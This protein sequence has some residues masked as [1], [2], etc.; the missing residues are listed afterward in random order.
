MKTFKGFLAVL[1]TAAM[2]V[3]VLA[4]SFSAS[5][6]GREFILGD[7]DGDS[8][9]TV[10]DATLV[11]KALAKMDEVREENMCAADGDHD[12]V[13]SVIDA[14][15]V[16]MWL[17]NFKV[18]YPIG[19]TVTE[20]L[21]DFLYPSEDPTQ[22]TQES[23]EP[24]T[25]EVTSE[26]TQEP[27]QAPTQEPTEEPTDAP[28]DP[29]TEPPTDP[30]TEPPTEFKPLKGVDISWANGDINL[31]K[32][33]EAGFDFV[34]IRCGYGDDLEY[35]DDSQFESNVRKA[36]EINMPWGTYLYSYALNLTEA[37][38]EV[39]HVKRLLK[40]K[41]PTLPVAFDMEDADNYKLRHGFPTNEM[42]IN[43][44]KTFLQGIE[45]ERYYPML[46]TN[47]DYMQNKL[48]DP[49]LLENFDIWYAQW[50]RECEYPGSRMGMWQYGGE[51]NFLEDN[52]IDG[53]GVIDKNYMYKDYPSIIKAGGYN[54]WPINYSITVTN[55]GVSYEC[56]VFSYSMV[57]DI[58]ADGEPIAASAGLDRITER[59]AEVEFDEIN[60][61]TPGFVPSSGR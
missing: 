9:V 3:S 49:T 21:L 28:T 41:R 19:F 17:A 48:N 39:E 35:Q 51:V 36:E 50:W 32:V 15:L 12:R 20:E 11:Q 22:P 16:Q 6:E 14:K 29:P 38:S 43:I 25:E 23:T 42:L 55:D 34:M 8:R 58:D 60:N 7:A 47:L 2:L 18:P 31:K 56:G 52:S 26:P 37:R 44:C 59:I 53:V 5:A 57:D 27:T 45:K 13:L 46:Y 1:L 10:L 24:P 30:P 4:M 40:N 33:K 54:N 61:H